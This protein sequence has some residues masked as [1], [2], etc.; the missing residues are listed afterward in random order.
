MPKSFER[1]HLGS[2]NVFRNQK[3]QKISR[4]Y[5]LMEFNNFRKN[6]HSAEKNPTGGPF[7]LASSFGRLKVCGLVR[8]SNPGSPASQK[9]S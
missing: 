9:I 6:S 2:L 5:P 3:I 8:K 4:K 7:V 1:G